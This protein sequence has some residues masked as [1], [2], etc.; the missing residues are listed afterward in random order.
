MHIFITGGAGFLGKALA[1]RLLQ[2]GHLIGTDGRDERIDQITLTDVVAADGF[3]DPRIAQTPA[4]SPTARCSGRSSRLEPPH[5]SP[6]GGRQRT[7]RSGFRSRD[8]GQPRRYARC[9]RFAVPRVTVR[10]WCLR[11]PSR[12]TARCP[13]WCSNPRRYA[14]NVMRHAESDRRAAGSR[15]HAKG[16]RRRP[17]AAAADRHRAPGKAQRRRI[18]VRQRDHQGAGER[19]GIDLPG[20]SVDADV[21]DLA[22]E[23]RRRLHPRA[24]PSGRSA[25]RQPIDQPAG[26]VGHGRRDGFGARTGGRSC[27]CR[28]HPLGARSADHQAGRHLARNT[29]CQ[30]GPRAR[31]PSIT[32][33]MPSCAPTSRVARAAFRLKAAATKLG[34]G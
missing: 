12:F 25:R 32:T 15:L 31:I 8:A 6:R 10:A 34:V 13:K 17:G 24:R 4:T 30:P 9:S 14:A 19:R 1:A 33:S 18:V 3:D 21:G 27:R 11:A 26:L 22:G 29:R 20:R 23:R 16:I 7:G 2:R 5:L 28:A